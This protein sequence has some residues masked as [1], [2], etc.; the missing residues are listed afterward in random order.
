MPDRNERYGAVGI[1]IADL[2]QLYRNQGREVPREFH[3]EAEIKAHKY[4]AKS[5]MLDGIK[6]ASTAEADAYT[7][8]KFWKQAGII[9]NLELQPVFILQEKQPGMRAIKYVADFRFEIDCGPEG[10]RDRIIDVKGVETA[11]FKMK[12]KLFAAKF[13]ELELQVWDRK[14]IKELSRV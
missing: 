4:Y 13:P 7:L 6:F 8:L 11:V 1:S 3:G 2:A 14:R 12:R 10:W 9:R 5:K